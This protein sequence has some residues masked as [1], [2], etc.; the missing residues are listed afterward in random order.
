MMHPATY[1]LNIIISHRKSQH[2][3]QYA[4][5]AFPSHLNFTELVQKVVALLGYTRI[6]P[7][8]KPNARQLV[9]TPAQYWIPVFVVVK[10][11]FRW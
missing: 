8:M 2:H 6:C 11:H 1:A 3:Q 5:E 9:D 4:C 10:N 7:R